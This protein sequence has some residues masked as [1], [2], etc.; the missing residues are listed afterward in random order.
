M[1]GMGNT[2]P[3]SAPHNGNDLILTYEKFPDSDK[4]DLHVL[5][6]KVI[7][8]GMIGM[9]QNKAETRE[10]EGRTLVTLR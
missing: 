3:G 5:A 1:T 8:P 7:S 9:L 10:D 2:M 4:Q 6:G